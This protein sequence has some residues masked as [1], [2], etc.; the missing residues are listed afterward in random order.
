MQLLHTVPIGERHLTS[1]RPL[2][3]K[4]GGDCDE[5]VLND[6]VGQPGPILL[7][8]NGGWSLKAWRRLRPVVERLAPAV[9]EDPATD[10]ATIAEI[11]DALP[12]TAIVLD[13][14]ITDH[15]AVDRA[16]S[17]AGGANVKVMRMGGV[18]E[19]LDAL[20]RLAAAGHTRMIGSFLEPQRSVAY[21]AQLSAMADWT[22]LDGHFW[23][24]GDP[25][26]MSYELDSSEP[27]IP[28]ISYDTTRGNW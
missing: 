19:T 22:D 11:R 1:H 10:D 2:K 8:V 13:E 14:P 26:V 15:A 23:I 25:Q 3:V 17:V 24:T 20:E 4:L 12:G 7:D 18:L 27:G 6:L 21:S 9:L 16:M 28:S 5:Q